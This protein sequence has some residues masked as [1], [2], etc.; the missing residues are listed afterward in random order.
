[1]N[2]CLLS[3]TFMLNIFNMIIKN[4]GPVPCTG[5]DFWVCI[6]LTWSLLP[7]VVVYCW[8]FLANT[9]KLGRGVVTCMGVS[10]SLILA[11]C[12]AGILTGE[13]HGREQKLLHWFLSKIYA[14]VLTKIDISVFA[15]YFNIGFVYVGSVSLGLRCHFSHSD[16]V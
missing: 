15:L 14:L 10:V 6:Q 9:V 5:V 7:N 13:Y 12:L 8:M 2:A 1:M 4:N 11:S 16:C 3:L